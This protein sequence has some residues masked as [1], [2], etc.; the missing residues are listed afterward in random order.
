MPALPSHILF[1]ALA[2]P[3]AGPSRAA[4]II[5]DPASNF[6]VEARVNGHP[7][8]LRVD[9]EASLIV[10]L[11]PDSA[12]R[13]GL[14][15]SLMRGETRIGPVRLTGSTRAAS[16]AIGG[17]ERRRRIAWTERPVVTDGD[18]VISPAFLP[19]DRITFAF[20][21]PRP[22]EGRVDLP[23]DR[24]GLGLFYR[25]S[26]G[27]EAIRIQFS[28]TRPATMATA[29]A[30]AHLAAHHGGRWTGEARE[31]P[32]EYGVL[33]PVRSFAL[34]R[35]A[36]LGGFGFD[37][38]LVRT[39]DNRGDLTLPPDPAADPDEIVVTARTRSRQRARFE[40]TFGLD[41]LSMCSS[42]VWDN[43]SRQLTLNC[44]ARE[45]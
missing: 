23:L 45:N 30:G 40:L 10:V 19:N 20:H 25:F 28:T 9:P 38:F 7:V 16:L 29:A 11:N 21:A 12:A 42:L 3:A 24:D 36:S 39:G 14:T 17:V 22:G 32:I 34:E 35:G 15:P 18:G 13:I 44:A 26:L 43:R 27:G 2:L 5:L 1:A 41:R 37:R 4:D 31:Q 8:R 6:I 33:R